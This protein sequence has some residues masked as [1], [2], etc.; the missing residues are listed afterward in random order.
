MPSKQLNELC[1]NNFSRLFGF[2]LLTKLNFN[3]MRTIHYKTLKGFMRANGIRQFTLEDFISGQCFSSQHGWM[4]FN[5]SEEA[6]NEYLRGIT[7][8]IWAKVTDERICRVRHAK[9]MGILRRLWFNGK[10][11]EYCA[12]QD[13]KGEIRFIQNHI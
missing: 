13:Y 6:A 12:G 10:R 3:I 1:P 2:E 11:Y 4:K 7:G 9:S 8:V 5:L